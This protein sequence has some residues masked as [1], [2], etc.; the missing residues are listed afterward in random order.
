MNGLD[1]IVLGIFVGSTVLGLMRGLIREVFSLAAW[2]LAFVGARLLGPA[3]APMLPG[4]ENPALQHAAALLLVFVLILL[5]TGLAGGVLAG[6]V[7][8]AGLGTYD[9]MLGVLF[10]ILRGVAAVVGLA[11]LAGLTALPKTQF[12]QAA[13]S[14]VPLEL[15]VHQLLPWLPKDVAVLI[16]Y[17]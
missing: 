8:L 5:A 6:L 16:K 3:L 17:S 12:W 9:R 2:V 13:L 11:L 4:A 10:G 1:L 15:A 14:R 7:K